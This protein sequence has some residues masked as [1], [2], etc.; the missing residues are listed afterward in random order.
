MPQYTPTD[1]LRYLTARSSKTLDF[2]IDRIGWDGL[3]E[4]DYE[5]LAATLEGIKVELREHLYAHT[6]LPRTY[7]DG[8]GVESAVQMELDTTYEHVW[9][10]DAAHS[11]N[12]PHVVLDKIECSS[13]VRRSVMVT[14]GENLVVHPRRE[15]AYSVA[16]AAAMLEAMGWTG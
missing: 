10:P 9:H 14:S 6:G 11:I 12:Q 8:R 3:T 1:S 2:V 5:D 4:G 7:D 13:G 16:E 15:V